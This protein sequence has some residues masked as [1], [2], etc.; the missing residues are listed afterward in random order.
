MAD[1]GNRGVA[2]QAATC[3]T[4]P[5]RIVVQCGVTVQQL[6]TQGPKSLVVAMHILLFG[7]KEQ[8]LDVT[9]H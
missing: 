6:Q 5:R 3:T 7:D 9:S 1:G 4:V 8:L 2:D